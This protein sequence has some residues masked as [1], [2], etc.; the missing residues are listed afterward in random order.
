M[1]TKDTVDVSYS[2]QLRREKFTVQLYDYLQEFRFVN[3]YA[4]SGKGKSG[5]TN[6]FI[7]EL[8]RRKAYPND[9]RIIDLGRL[10][11]NSREDSIKDLLK[12]KFGP[13]FDNNMNEY[14]KGTKQLIVF[15]NFSIVFDG[16][17]RYPTYF[18]RALV[19]HNIH[20]IF[21]TRKKLDKIE[22]IDCFKAVELEELDPEESLAFALVSDSRKVYGCEADISNLMHHEILKSCQGNPQK[23]R[24]R[25]NDLFKSMVSSVPL[26]STRSTT[27]QP[28]NEEDRDFVEFAES[29][30]VASRPVTEPGAPPQK[31]QSEAGPKWKKSSNPASKRGRRA[32]EPD[33]KS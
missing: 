22:E 8:I 33:W 30:S 13:K 17:Y 4:P 24:D 20:A 15:D 14:F 16:K 10:Q 19:D 32:R 9:V 3:L 23:I 12:E 11:G 27:S 7:N 18:L 21:I 26:A 6:Y 31:Q 1:A 29:V 2:F 25:A 28:V 5:F